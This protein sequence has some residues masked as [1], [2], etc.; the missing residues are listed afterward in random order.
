MDLKKITSTLLSSD[1]ISGL[2][3][4]T[5]S[6][7]KDVTSVLTSALPSLLTGANNQAKDNDTAESFANALADHAKA[8]TSNLTSFLGKVDM[9]DGAK[10]V[11]HLLGSGKSDVTDSVAKETGVSSKQTGQILSAAAPLMMSLLGQ[12]ADKDENKADG[13]GALVGSLLDNVDLVS[14]LTGSSSKDDEK[15]EKEDKKK[16]KKDKKKEKSGVSGLLGGLL[17]KLLK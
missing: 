1:S 11:T 4:L 13:I 8:D 16:D 5:G 10:I 15:E 3:S 12:Q 17:G 6:S 9:A 7:K 2:S 14:L